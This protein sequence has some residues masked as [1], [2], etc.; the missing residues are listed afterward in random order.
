MAQISNICGMLKMALFNGVSI[1]GSRRNNNNGI[2]H[3]S[4]MARANSAS[5]AKYR[6]QLINKYINNEK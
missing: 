4:I 3:Q 1:C 5:V 2:S 6:R